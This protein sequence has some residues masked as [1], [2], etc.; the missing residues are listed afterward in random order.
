MLVGAVSAVVLS[1]T[2]PDGRNTAVIGRTTAE[3]RRHRAVGRARLVVVRQ[4]E[5]VRTRAGKLAESRGQ[6]AQVRT[7]SVV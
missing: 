4:M 5:K 6:Q 2:R 3:L 7:S 1:I